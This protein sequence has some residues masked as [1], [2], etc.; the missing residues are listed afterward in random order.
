MNEGGIEICHSIVGH[1]KA[2]T[3]FPACTLEGHH[4]SGTGC[5]VNFVCLVQL[6]WTNRLA[7]PDFDSNFF[8]MFP[9]ST[10]LL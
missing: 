3:G 4:M 2:C 8:L 10:S 6:I 7:T 9:C 1:D 5:V